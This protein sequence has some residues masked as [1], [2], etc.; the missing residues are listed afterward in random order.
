MWF[1]TPLVPEYKCFI[2]L[3]NLEE[4]SN[5]LPLTSR[6]AWSPFCRFFPRPGSGM[7]ALM[8]S[9]T[10][11]GPALG[12]GQPEVEETRLEKISRGS[13]R[14]SKSSY[15]M[16]MFSETNT[17]QGEFSTTDKRGKAL[18]SERKLYVSCRSAGNT[19]GFCRSQSVR[20]EFHPSQ[21]T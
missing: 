16:V 7:Q 10:Q 6:R 18:Y 12:S 15:L 13:K 3:E 14:F 20:I 17:C 2:W 9:V 5:V 19:G 8:P 21:F 1:I 11:A 4:K